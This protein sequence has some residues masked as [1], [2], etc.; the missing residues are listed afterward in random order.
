MNPELSQVVISFGPSPT[1]VQNGVQGPFSGEDLGL[2]WLDW[3]RRLDP[4]VLSR[5]DLVL[6][7]PKK[8]AVED[9]LLTAWRSFKRIDENSGVQA[10]P[11]GPNLVFQQIQWLYVHEKLKG[12]FLWC[13]PDCIPVKAGWLDILAKEY[14]RCSKPFMGRLVEAQVAGGQR[15]PKHLSGNAIY[16]NQAYTVAPKIME[17]SSMPWDVWAAEQILPKSHFT[18]AIQHDYRHPEIKDAQELK[19]LLRP[20]TVLFHSD[21]YGAIARI[22]SA[23]ATL[24]PAQPPAELM[25]ALRDDLPASLERLKLVLDGPDKQARQAILEFC[26]YAQINERSRIAREKLQ[27]LSARYPLGDALSTLSG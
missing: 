8:T 9:E 6:L 10:W 24:E 3:V 23:P 13:E 25:Q 22:L 12:P 21:K 20:E 7:V 19:T 4:E 2:M 14:L 18:N 5:Y 1:Y 27:Q 26:D 15:I 16:P 17:A 11:R